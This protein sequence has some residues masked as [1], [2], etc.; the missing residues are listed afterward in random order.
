MVKVFAIILAGG[1]G[2]RSKSSTPKQLLNINGSSLLELTIKKFDS[3]INIHEIIVVVNKEFSTWNLV[4]SLKD[5]YHKVNSIVIGGNSRR[6]STFNG[7]KEISVDDS[8]VLIHDAVRPFV[9][10]RT[11]NNCV[12]SLVDYDA[13]YPAVS[14]ADTIIEIDEEGLVKN[15]PLRKNMLRGQTPQGFKTSLIKKAHYYSLEDEKVDKEVTNDCGLIT[16]YN[17]GK[18]KVV[19]GNRENIKITFPEDIL[20]VERL[21]KNELN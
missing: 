17:L 13:V 14:S 15:I 18:I 3:N 21:Y 5:K 1:I 8:V 10:H 16:R 6:E 12:K 2:S 9:S 19:E 11:I 7:L 20:L 4:E